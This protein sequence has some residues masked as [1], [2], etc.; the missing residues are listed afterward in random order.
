MR[1]NVVSDIKAI[2]EKQREERGKGDHLSPA[3]VHAHKE[4]VEKSEKSRRR[5]VVG[6]SYLLRIQHDVVDQ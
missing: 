6:V 2:T 4:H 3:C 1:S 5:A